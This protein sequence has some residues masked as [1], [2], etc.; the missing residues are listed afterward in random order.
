MIIIAL[1]IRARRGL[2]NTRGHFLFGIVPF[3]PAGLVYTARIPNYLYTNLRYGYL[4][5]I[6]IACHIFSNGFYSFKEIFH[7]HF[8]KSQKKILD[9]SPPANHHIPN[10]NSNRLLEN[11][12]RPKYNPLLFTKKK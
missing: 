4:R 1:L 7:D 11:N 6:L 9:Q 12:F 2:D 3:L 10:L 8:K 5:F